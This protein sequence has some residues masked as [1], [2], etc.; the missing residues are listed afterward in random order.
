MLEKNIL[1]SKIGCGRYI[2]QNG[3][4][5]NASDELRKLGT[6]LLLVYTSISQDLVASK[7]EL[8]LIKA[9][10]ELHRCIHDGFCCI[11]DAQI[12]AKQYG[13]SVDAIVGIGGGVV[14]DFS[15]IIADFLELPLATIPTSSAT[16][17]AYT[18]LSVCYTQDGKSVGS[19]KYSWPVSLVLADMDVLSCQP[20][21]LFFAGILDAMSKKIEVEQRIRGKSDSEID[22]GFGC[23]YALA[24]Y[25]YEHMMKNL[26]EACLDIRSQR[27]SKVMY[28]MVY[29]SI[30]G[31]GVVSGLARGSRQS[32]IGHKFYLFIRTY[33]TKECARFLHG[34]LV[35]IGLV[36]QL[37]FNGDES[38]AKKFQQWLRKMELPCCVPDLGVPAGQDTL[39]ACY[40]SILAS[41][42]MQEATP[43]EIPRMR[44]AM[45]LVFAPYSEA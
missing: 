1:A 13:K 22:P 15:K 45:E 32:A 27:N 11:E 24:C 26:E 9:G 40:E 2:Q 31:A 21:R 25:F 10:F 23:C 3:I 14:L 20:P 38:Q 33:Y 41:S 12:I 16:C 28:D 5:A 39:D 4:L 36:G 6:K 17:A 37:Y 42:A 8:G 29:Y 19:R 35:A 34:E 7:L 44:K 18:P 43:A 30:V